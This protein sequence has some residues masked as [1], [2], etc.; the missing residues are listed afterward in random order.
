MF[1]ATLLVT[2]FVVELDTAVDASK[3]PVAAG[4]VSVLV[5]ATAEA[6]NVIAPDVSPE[7][8]IELILLSHLPICTI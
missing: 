8:T 7:I 5:P 2:V 1:I 4:N 6:C 3:L